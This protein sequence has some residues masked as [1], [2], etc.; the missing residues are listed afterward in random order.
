MNTNGTE[1]I[2]RLCGLRRLIPHSG[3]ECGNYCGFKGCENWLIG[4]FLREVA[5]ASSITND[6]VAS[7]PDQ[8]FVENGGMQASRVL[9]RKHSVKKRI[10]IQ[11]TA[12]ERWSLF[13]RRRAKGQGLTAVVKPQAQVLQRFCQSRGRIKDIVPVGGLRRLIELALYKLAGTAGISGPEAIGR[14]LCV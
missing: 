14:Y 7:K 1:L 13:L 12:Q 9:Y 6:Q 11:V 8:V 4:R 3:A 2:N 10:L 5:P